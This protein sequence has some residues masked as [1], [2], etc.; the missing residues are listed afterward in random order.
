MVVSEGLRRLIVTRVG[1]GQPSRRCLSMWFRRRLTTTIHLVQITYDRNMYHASRSGS[2]SPVMSDQGCH[3]AV[4]IILL[5]NVAARA[6]GGSTA[7]SSTAQNEHPSLHNLIMQCHR[8]SEIVFSLA[9][10]RT[11][12]AELGAT[13][14]QVGLGYGR[15]TVKHSNPETARPQPVV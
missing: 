3:V 7:R 9:R 12:S 1:L 15:G 10:T 5:A 6:S 11:S 2:A 14:G 4:D 8:V 13:L